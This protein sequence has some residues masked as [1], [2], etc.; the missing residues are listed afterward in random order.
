ME[1]D[2]AKNVG[3][4]QSQTIAP[5]HFKASERLREQARDLHKKAV[6]MEQLANEVSYLSPEANQTLIDI[7]SMLK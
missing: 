3:V 2:N 6:G 4:G 1:Y 5:H 7:F